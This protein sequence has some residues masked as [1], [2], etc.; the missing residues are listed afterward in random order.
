MAK[1]T[2]EEYMTNTYEDYGSGIVGPKI[3]EKAY[4]ELKGQILKELHDNTFSGS[5]DEDA[6]EHIDVSNNEDAKENIEKVLEIVDL[7]HI[8]DVTQELIILRVFLVSLTET[9]SRWQR[10][11]PTSS[12]DNWETLKKKFWSKCRP[13]ARTA[14]KMEEINNFQQEPDETL[15]GSDNED[16]KEHIEKVL[17]IVD[18]FHIH[19]VTQEEIILRV[20]PM[21]LTETT[22]RWTTNKPTGS[23]DNWETLKKKLLS[24]CCPPARTSN[25]MEEIKNFPQETDET[26]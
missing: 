5:D 25:K 6:K 22:S 11:K 9:A 15:Y 24:K 1:P 12:I 20:F 4:F 21:S 8:H 17:D 2:M 3:Y 13:P 26:L 23:I 14:K 10:N 16:A 7:F 18:L 19:D